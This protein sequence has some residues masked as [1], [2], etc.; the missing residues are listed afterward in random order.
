M[1]WRFVK[2]AS[3]AQAQKE[4]NVIIGL[5]PANT[6]VVRGLKDEGAKLIARLAN[7]PA[8]QELDQ[9]MPNSYA[10]ALYRELA[11]GQL[12]KQSAADA[13]HA[14]QKYVRANPVK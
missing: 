1:A 5:A 14:L 3:D 6:S 10:L 7:Q 12:Q 11:L 13:L 2:I 4:A 9:V 8:I